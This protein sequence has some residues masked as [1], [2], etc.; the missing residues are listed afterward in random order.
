M[1]CATRSI[2]RAAGRR[3]GN[4]RKEDIPMLDAL[5]TA[6]AIT[7]ER[8]TLA[9]LPIG[10]IEQHSRHL[11]LG[12]D[13]IA[14]TALAHRVGVELGALTLPALPVSMGRCHKPMA[15]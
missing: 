1:P 6:T 8:P 13:W 5:S 3:T 15:G 14:A 2:P 12:T 4:Y 7:R 10:S 11:P 9:V